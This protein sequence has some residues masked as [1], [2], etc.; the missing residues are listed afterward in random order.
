MLARPSAPAPDSI[1]S[2]STVMAT[3]STASRRAL[4]VCDVQ[5]GIL[6]MIFGDNSE[7]IEAYVGRCNEAIAHAR[8]KN[9]KV[10]F[11]R[12]GFQPG[13]P[14]IGPKNKVSRI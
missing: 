12:V 2:R 10:I 5:L 3:T 6:P 1:S 9:D 4:I 13:H 14:E 7:A 11:I 8:S